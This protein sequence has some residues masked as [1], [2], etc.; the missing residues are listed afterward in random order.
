MA[1]QGVTARRIASRKAQDSSQSCAVTATALYSILLVPNAQGDFFFSHPTLEKG[2]TVRGNRRFHDFP[3][4]AVR[5]VQTE[6]D[7]RK[8]VIAS[9]RIASHIPATLPHLNQPCLTSNRVRK[10]VDI[11]TLRPGPSLPLS[12]LR[13]FF[14][15]YVL[16]ELPTHAHTI[17]ALS[18]RYLHGFIF[19]P[20]PRDM[21]NSRR[22]PSHTS[23]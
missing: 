11:F 17:R 19:H 9:R 20:S 4:V 5:F 6:N 7:N 16:A 21:T 12:K 10:Q 22:H 8:A 18:M 13:F 23:R 15:R 14:S 2:W 1:R 3:S